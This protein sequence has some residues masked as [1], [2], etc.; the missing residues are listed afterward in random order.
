[1]VLEGSVGAGSVKYVALGDSLTA[2][3]GSST[4][5]ETFVYSYASHLLEKHSKV[6][7][8]NFAQPGGTTVDVLNYQVPQAITEQ[9]EY[10]TLLIGVNDIHN[11][12][13][14]TDFKKKYS[15]IL[16]EL[17]TQTTAKIT[18]IEIPYIGSS[19]LVYPPFNYLLNAR[20]QL[21]N[22]TI[23]DLVTKRANTERVQL[24][25]LYKETY[26]YSKQNNQYY[27]ADLFH[28]SGEGYTFWGK[29]INAY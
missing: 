24:V 16:D 15:A 2:G 26:L 20:T 7:I 25:P 9:P 23:L 29:I 14:N 3:V 11:K 28:P 1:M 4:V 5:D 10:I 8:L 6:E 17:L 13:T 18:V 21:F 27:S 22:K 19:R 12:R